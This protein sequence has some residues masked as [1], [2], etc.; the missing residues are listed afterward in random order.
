MCY[1]KVTGPYQVFLTGNFVLPAD[2]DDQSDDDEDEM[3]EDLL[4]PDEIDE[5]LEDGDSEE[6]ELDALADP[7]LVEVGED[8]EEEAP[9]LV[10]VETKKGKNKR[11]AEASDEPEHQILDKILKPADSADGEQKLSKKQKKKLKNNA[12]E[13][14]PVVAKADLMVTDEPKP[15]T[16]VTGKDSPA[17][18]KKVQFAK[19]LEQ[20]PTPT[21]NETSK[22]GVKVVQGVTLD[23]KKIGTGKQVKKGS[24]VELR[25]IGKL[26][27]G[28]VFDGLS[29]LVHSYERP[30]LTQL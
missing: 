15:S 2:A 9:K 29:Q 23:D 5:Y 14:V 27:D 16:K 20:G 11:L 30:E 4:Q 19:N 1:F 12:G 6:D 18:G 24:T 21:K 17:N 3:D 26:K 28:K 7:R 8:D 10:K 13:A 25:Y 22:I